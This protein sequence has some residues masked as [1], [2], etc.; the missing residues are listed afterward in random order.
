MNRYE[1]SDGS[2]REEKGVALQ[3]GVENSPVEV[4]GLY[5]YINEEG[6]TIE[7]HY[8]ANQHGFVPESEVIDPII[9]S[10]ARSLVA[11]KAAQ[12]H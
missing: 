6:K 2:V 11:A 3:P 8:S 10:N 7:V 4:S 5:R 1:Q 9:T 12:L